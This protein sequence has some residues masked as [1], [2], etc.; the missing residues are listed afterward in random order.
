LGSPHKEQHDHLSG[1]RQTTAGFVPI[2][3]SMAN[4][5]QAIVLQRL[6]RA[7]EALD[8]EG[9]AAAETV[10]ASERSVAE[11]KKSAEPVTRKRTPRG[12]PKRRR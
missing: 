11:G 5:E 10:A 9:Q 12:A 8:A 4:D 2:L 7:F 3:L 6:K 1:S